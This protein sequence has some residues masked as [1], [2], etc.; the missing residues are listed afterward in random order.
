MTLKFVKEGK[1]VYA[2]INGVL[3][4]KPCRNEDEARLYA[5]KV[6]KGLV[7]F[8]PLATTAVRSINLNQT[9]Y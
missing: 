5:D 2:Q 9:R 4:S 8:E 1:F 7:R 6:N 3:A